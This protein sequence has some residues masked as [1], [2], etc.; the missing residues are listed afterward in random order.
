[1][2]GSSAAGVTVRFR[3]PTR[4]APP[5]QQ[6]GGGGLAACRQ[7]LRVA[8]AAPCASPRGFQLQSTRVLGELV[9]PGKP[10]PLPAPAELRVGA[11]VL[12][13]HPLSGLYVPAE[14]AAAAA[15]GGAP[16]LVY[17]QASTA[18][19]AAEG[20]PAVGG[21][22]AAPGLPAG[23]LPRLAAHGGWGHAAVADAPARRCPAAQE[24]TRRA[25]ALSDILLSQFAS[26]PDG[27]G[28]GS[29][30]EG[31]WSGDEEGDSEEGDGSGSGGDSEEASEEGE[32][33]E[34]AGLGGAAWDPFAHAR[35]GLPLL[36]LL[37]PEAAL[38]AG[39]GRPACTAVPPRGETLCPGALRPERPAVPCRDRRQAAAAGRQTDTAHF[40]DWE[41]HSRGIASKLLARMGFVRGKGLGRSGARRWLPRGPAVG[42]RASRWACALLA[43]K[44]PIQRQA[45][46]LPRLLL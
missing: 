19:C 20:A 32:E 45:P 7:L 2:Q 9:Q 35:C 13:L 6:G 39:P 43:G 36:W 17:L 24:G 38:R 31:A 18:G 22:P 46:C 41:V 44:V 5:S 37:P 14:V 30:S 3:H 8:A 27:G 10:P 16:T 23:P 25:V 33:A 29:G 26:S 1:V 21:A 40:A 34:H 11:A 4:W 15:P 28:S 42:A 12:A